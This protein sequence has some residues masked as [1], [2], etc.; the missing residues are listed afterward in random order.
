MLKKK[1]NL[2]IPKKRKLCHLID[3]AI[4]WIMF[5]RS[6]IYSYIWELANLTL[7]YFCW[8][9]RY[10]ILLYF[11]F[12]TY[13]TLKMTSSM[14]GSGTGWDCDSH[15]GGAAMKL[16]SSQTSS[17][18]AILHKQ[19]D[20]QWGSNLAFTQHGQKLFFPL[21]HRNPRKSAAASRHSWLFDCSAMMLS[22]TFLGSRW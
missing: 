22:C 14:P 11:W 19:T 13:L 10:T 16:Q 21:T 3:Q 15:W 9:C 20:A 4:V 8:T 7:H 17:F 18:W 5:L 12:G 1:E 2:F 6:D